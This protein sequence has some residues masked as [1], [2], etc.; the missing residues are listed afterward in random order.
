MLKIVNTF[1]SHWSYLHFLNMWKPHPRVMSEH[2]FCSV[3]LKAPLRCFS[4][5][6][7]LMSKT[8]A[9]KCINVKHS[10]VSLAKK[11]RLES[12][13]KAKV[14]VPPLEGALRPPVDT[15]TDLQVERVSLRKHGSVCVIWLLQWFPPHTVREFGF[16][17]QPTINILQ[18]RSFVCLQTF[19]LVW[20]QPLLDV[21]KDTL[22]TWK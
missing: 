6:G 3:L 18:H 1:I 4:S 19:K 11:W 13:Q 9:A 20:S 21:A 8:Q 5:S 17:Y 16:C 22:P 10:Y 2:L 12:L 15:L 7:I 14:R